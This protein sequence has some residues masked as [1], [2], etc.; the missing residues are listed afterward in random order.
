MTSLNKGLVKNC[1]I[2]KVTT[3]T[4]CFFLKLKNGYLVSAKT[5][6]F[7]TFDKL[8]QPGILNL[9]NTNL[10]LNSSGHFYVVTLNL[11]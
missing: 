3:F 2:E 11:N 9:N 6:R 4:D 1:K 7:A 5:G 10:D 8:D